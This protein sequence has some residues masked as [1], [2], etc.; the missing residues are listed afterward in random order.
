[1]FFASDYWRT[2]VLITMIVFAMLIMIPSYVALLLQS[3]QR[4]NTKM[5]L[6]AIHD[7]LVPIY[8]RRG[9]KDAFYKS[10]RKDDNDHFYHTL[11]FCDLDGFKEV[12][13]MARHATGDRMLIEITRLLKEQVREGDAVA[14][15]GGD[16]FGLLLKSCPLKKGITIADAICNKINNYVLEWDEIELKVGISVG[17]VGVDQNDE[18]FNRV[19]KFADMA[20]YTAKNS[21]GNQIY[22]FEEPLS[23]LDSNIFL[24]NHSYVFTG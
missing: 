6:Q 11:L 15:L 14:S 4:A 5:K 1:V 19:L 2:E 21:G 22:V 3:L 9:F 12:N 16:E 24:A 17:V 8:N 10:I 23:E 7:P 13:D 18:D 20:C